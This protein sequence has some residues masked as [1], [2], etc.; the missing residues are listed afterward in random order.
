MKTAVLAATAVFFL[1]L[2]PDAHSLELDGRVADGLSREGI[3]HLTVKLTA[4][5]A[6][7]QPER[8]TNTD[9]RG[10]FQFTGLGPGRYLLEVYQGVTVLHREVVTINGNTRKDVDLRRR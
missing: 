8:I 6:A 3:P 5:K 1:A 10:R 7:G 4:P 9:R 2:I